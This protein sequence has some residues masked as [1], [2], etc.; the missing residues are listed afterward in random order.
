MAGKHANEVQ[1]KR[2]TE[3]NEARVVLEV[4]TN[5][6]ALHCNEAALLSFS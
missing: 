5:C 1:G 4:R 2:T 6:T 3:G